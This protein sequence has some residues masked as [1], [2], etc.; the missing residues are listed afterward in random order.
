MLYTKDLLQEATAFTQMQYIQLRVTR[1]FMALITSGQPD[2]L[3]LSCKDYAAGINAGPCALN[4][5]DISFG[6]YLIYK[7]TYLVD[8]Y[9]IL[10]EMKYHRTPTLRQKPVFPDNCDV[11]EG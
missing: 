1:G 5:M 9:N 10:S 11:N 7:T 4:M 8:L 3:V 6:D 2:R